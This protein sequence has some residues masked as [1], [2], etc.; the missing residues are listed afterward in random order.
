MKL[1]EEL[2]ELISLANDTPD[3]TTQ[4]EAKAK[5]SAALDQLSKAIND[6][7]TSAGVYVDTVNSAD[8]TQAI[9]N[10]NVNTE[11]I[12]NLLS[13]VYNAEPT[14]DSADLE[15]VDVDIEPVDMTNLLGGTDF[16]QVAELPIQPTE[17]PREEEE[18]VVTT[19]FEKPDEIED[20][21]DVDSLEEEPS[22]DEDQDEE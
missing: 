2:E 16:D 3:L 12:K 7:H 10:L 1:I 6:F 14:E 20:E 4:L 22:E 9:D 17:L 8:L 15:T 13:G 11:K 19:S 5:I 21:E 18:E